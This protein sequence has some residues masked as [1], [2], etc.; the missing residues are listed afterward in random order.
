MSQPPLQNCPQERDSKNCL[1]LSCKHDETKGCATTV[2]R[3]LYRVISVRRSKFLFWKPWSNQRLTRTLQKPWRKP[4]HFLYQRYPYT[5]FQ[6]LTAL[7]AMHVSRVIRGR[8]VHILIDSGSTHNFLNSK[9]ARK[10]DYCKVPSPTFRVMLAT[11]SAYNAMR[12][13]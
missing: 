5:P 4:N 3:D 7:Q 6:G 9:F 10:L 8:L 1:E 11:E 2:M 12:F 13:T